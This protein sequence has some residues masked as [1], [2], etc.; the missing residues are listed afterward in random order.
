MGCGVRSC[1]G[2]IGV[3][4]RLYTDDEEG[5]YWMID[6]DE[7]YRQNESDAIANVERSGYTCVAPATR[8]F[9]AYSTHTVTDAYY[10]SGIVYTYDDF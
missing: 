8:H 10:G 1:V 5:D 3:E 7:D 4:T 2:L 6:D 9:E